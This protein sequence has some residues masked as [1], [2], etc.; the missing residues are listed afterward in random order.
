[1]PVTTN[2]LEGLLAILNGNYSARWNFPAVVGTTVGSHA[3]V[4][5]GVTLT[6]SFPTSLPSYASESGFAAFTAAEKAAASAED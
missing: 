6:Y 3:G 4:G 5:Q 1:M 2:A